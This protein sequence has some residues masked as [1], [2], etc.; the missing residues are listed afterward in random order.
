MSTPI[1]DFP[2][3]TRQ[4]RKKA[5]RMSI[6]IVLLNEGWSIDHPRVNSCIDALAAALARHDPATADYWDRFIPLEE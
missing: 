4:E 5:A 3:P 2:A 1:S 6:R